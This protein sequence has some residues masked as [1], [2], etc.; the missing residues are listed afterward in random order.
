VP[1]ADEAQQLG[2]RVAFHVRIIPVGRGSF[3][4]RVVWERGVQ[5]P[6]VAGGGADGGT[7][8]AKNAVT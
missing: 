6:V 2:R 3:G 5:L 4:S 8:G 1:A 7:G